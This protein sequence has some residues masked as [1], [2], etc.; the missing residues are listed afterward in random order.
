MLEMNGIGVRNR[1]TPR[2]EAFDVA[3]RLLGSFFGCDRIDRR[4]LSRRL[5]A[6]GAAVGGEA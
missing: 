6:G 5:R 1:R 4:A 3:P 2:Q